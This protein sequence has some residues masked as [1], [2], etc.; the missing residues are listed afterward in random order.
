MSAG[1]AVPP[2]LVVGSFFYLL[3]NQRPDEEEDEVV[4]SAGSAIFAIEITPISAC[5]AAA[6]P[7]RAIVEEK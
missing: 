6:L 2:D 7:T 5:I 3:F 1:T 4:G